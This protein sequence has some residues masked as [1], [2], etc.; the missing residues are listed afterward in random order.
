MTRGKVVNLQSLPRRGRGGGIGVF[1]G[2]GRVGMAGGLRGRGNFRGRGRGEGGAGGSRGGR[3]GM[4]RRRDD[5]A[6]KDEEYANRKQGKG[7]KGDEVE[8]FEEKQSRMAREVGVAT[9][10]EPNTTLGSLVPYLPDVAT[11][12]NPL[13]R[14]ATAMA[15]MRALTGGYVDPNPVIHAEDMHSQFRNNGSMFFTDLRTR[16]AIEA[17]GEVGGVDDVVKNT[18]VKRAILGEY[19]GV[20]APSHKDAAGVVRNSLTKEAS[21]QGS[22][23]TAFEEKLAELVA[24]AKVKQA[25]PAAAPKAAE[26][27]KGKGKKG[28][29]KA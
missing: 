26:E 5:G 4:R 19:D 1:R 29:A 6:N 7:K 8:T 3:G 18:I 27:P 25:K 21:Y 20:E 9:R 15:N 11:D 17:Q 28:K 16:A 22:K 24:K 10:Y 23:V 14:L 2:M 12:S 13:G